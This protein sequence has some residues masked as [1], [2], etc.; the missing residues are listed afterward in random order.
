MSAAGPGESVGDCHGGWGKTAAGEEQGEEQGKKH[1]ATAGPRGTGPQ[2]ETAWA[3]VRGGCSSRRWR[4]SCVRR[5]RCCRMAGR[6]G[7]RG[8]APCRRSCE[9]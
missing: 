1:E 9:L 6:K 5:H 8:R 4:R 3:W 7:G 2:E